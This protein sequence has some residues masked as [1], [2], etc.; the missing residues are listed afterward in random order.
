MAGG[1]ARANSVNNPIAT[2]PKRRYSAR[3]R[4]CGATA[5]WRRCGC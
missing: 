4:R 5:M 1:Q 3:Q 2:A